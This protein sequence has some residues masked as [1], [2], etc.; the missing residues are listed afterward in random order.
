MPATAHAYDAELAA[1]GESRS[2][3]SAR[4]PRQQRRKD[5]FLEESGGRNGGQLRSYSREEKDVA[6]LLRCCAFSSM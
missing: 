4:L 5:T 6:G 3:P 2:R 1:R